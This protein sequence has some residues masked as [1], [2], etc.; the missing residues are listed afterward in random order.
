ML[1][2]LTSVKRRPRPRPQDAEQDLSRGLLRL[3]PV[4]VGARPRGALL[5][6]RAE[7]EDDGCVLFGQQEDGRRALG[8]FSRRQLPVCRDHHG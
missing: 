8:I 5:R 3:R 4:A 1:R 6:V 2:L 7:A